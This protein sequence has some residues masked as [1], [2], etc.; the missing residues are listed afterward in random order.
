MESEADMGS[1]W[2]FMARR[3][4]QVEQVAASTRTNMDREPNSTTLSLY[5]S[6]SRSQTNNSRSSN[7]DNKSLSPRHHH[8]SMN[9]PDMNEDH[10]SN[11]LAQ[12]EGVQLQP[13]QAGITLDL[14][15]SIGAPG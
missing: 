5:P 11:S 8:H 6:S 4:D 2:A 12:S 14:T 3:Q 15:M 7:Y 10:D 1:P 13:P 9:L